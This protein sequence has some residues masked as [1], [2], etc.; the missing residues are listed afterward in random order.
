MDTLEC[1]VRLPMR[2]L[3]SCTP[4]RSRGMSPCLFVALM[5][6]HTTV[7]MA[8]LCP[9]H[10]LTCTTS[11]ADVDAFTDKSR[12][13][14]K[15]GD[16]LDYFKFFLTRGT[17]MA[18]PI[19]K[20]NTHTHPA[21]NPLSHTTAMQALNN[22]A[23]DLSLFRLLYTYIHIYF[24]FSISIDSDDQSIYLSMYINVRHHRPAL[25]TLVVHIYTLYSIDPIP[26]SPHE[27]TESVR[28]SH[29]HTPDDGLH[30]DC[31]HGRQRQRRVAGHVVV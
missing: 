5:W 3:E 25:R 2:L 10:R 13:Y 4:F 8:S 26:V 9:I 20:V 22:V 16:N 23:Y 27:R 1:P 29:S 6:T 18:D 31:D 17:Y 19:T 21:T 14:F 7:D 11:A 30:Y 15:A 12:L 28:H 24:S